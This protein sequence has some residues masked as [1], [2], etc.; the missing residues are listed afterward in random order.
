MV[1]S[2]KKQ[3]VTRDGRRVSML[4]H[5]P[6]LPSGM[7]RHEPIRGFIHPDH[8]G[9]YNNTPGEQF[10]WTRNG[11]GVKGQKCEFDLV[12]EYKGE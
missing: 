10:T 2:V 1:I 12:S 8:R 9:G 7:K 3:Y 6:P 11:C 5:M 4:R